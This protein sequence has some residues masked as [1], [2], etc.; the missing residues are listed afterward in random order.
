MNL[1]DEPTLVFTDVDRPK[2]A[3]ASTHQVRIEITECGPSTTR[4]DS[5]E[6]LTKWMIERVD[7]WARACIA[8]RRVE[9]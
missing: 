2:P 9:S 6:T 8:E 5:R 3:E 7:Y 1:N 4:T